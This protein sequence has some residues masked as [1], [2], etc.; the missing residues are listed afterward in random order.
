MA[1]P[2]WRDI[3]ASML[4]G[5]SNV[6]DLCISKLPLQWLPPTSTIADATT[7]LE[8]LGRRRGIGRGRQGVHGQCAALPLRHCNLA[9][10]T[11]ALEATLSNLLAAATR[12]PHR[13]RREFAHVPFPGPPHMS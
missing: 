13:A 10:T 6:F 2:M 8:G 1:L 4:C 12:L 3:V 5:P 9:S 7:E 11:A